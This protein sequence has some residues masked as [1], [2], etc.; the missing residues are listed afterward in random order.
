MKEIGGF[1]ELEL[2][3]VKKEYHKNPIHLNSG[4]SAL[5]YIL[6]A[7][8]VTEIHLPYYSC[9]SIITTVNN[10]GIKIE[11]YNIDSNFYPL[12]E[13]TSPSSY[14]L[15]INYFGVCDQQ[16]Q[17]V[18]ERF[19]NVIIDNTQAFFSLP[20]K[21]KDT[22]YSPRKF[23]GVSDGGYLYTD[24]LIEQTLNIDTSFDQMTHL[25]KRID[26]SANESYSLFQE[27]EEQL[28]HSGIRSMSRITRRIL[29]SIDYKSAE[30]IRVRNFK[31]LHENLGEYNELIF[32]GSENISIPMVYPLMLN[33][34]GLKEALIKE[35]IFIAT[36]WKEALK[37]Q[38]ITNFEANLVTKLLA[39]P[40]DQRYT[41]DDMRR[42]VSVVRT[43]IEK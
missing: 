13:K 7:K 3:I 38:R 2:P 27:H 19:K 5:K 40:I 12:I 33:K 14:L 35:S 25:L 10:A 6:I 37:S 20:L 30:E 24:T 32:T 1:F 43:L 9:E 42:I 28:G 31:Y 15:Y 36:Y 16:V 34:S 4:R 22:F 8:K 23:F 29:G 26:I 21:G 18:A 41:V 17:D 39:L 11:F